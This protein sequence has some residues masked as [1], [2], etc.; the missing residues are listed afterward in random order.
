MKIK[1]IAAIA[2]LG[3]ILGV[4][5]LV[6]DNQ[7]AV[8]SGITPP[9]SDELGSTR[10]PNGLISSYFQTA[11]VGAVP[12]ATS[13]FGTAGSLTAGG[14]WSRNG[15]DSCEISGSFNDA[16]TTL[17][18]TLNPFRATS[19]VELVALNIT[20]GA[21]TSRTFYV[22]TTTT[23]YVPKLGFNCTA[24]APTT[25]EGFLIDE[26][27]LATST[28]ASG[29]VYRGAQGSITANGRVSA[30]GGFINIGN[31]V[32]SMIVGPDEYAAIFSTST[33]ANTKTAENDHKTCDN[34]GCANNGGSDGVTN[35]S[36]TFDG[37]YFWRWTKW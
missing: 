28:S 4:I 7:S 8:D 10:Y 29:G 24:G 3:A 19:T 35:S 30:L 20:S 14:C 11:D 5:G 2:V 1:I 15:V 25:C 23:A 13:T 18:S 21:S 33:Y 6:G 17:N 22:G 32:A 12:V 27:I 36:N 9:V 37:T 16:S 34:G 26:A 31:S